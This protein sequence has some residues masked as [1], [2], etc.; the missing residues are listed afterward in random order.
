MKTCVL[1]LT[2][3][4][5]IIIHV[6]E[7]KFSIFEM[8]LINYVSFMSQN[9]VAFS[10]LFHFNF[11]LALTEWSIYL[12]TQLSQV[13]PKSFDIIS[14]ELKIALKLSIILFL[15]FADKKKWSSTTTFTKQISFL[16]CITMPEF[17]VQQAIKKKNKKKKERFEKLSDITMK[18]W[19]KRIED[20]STNANYCTYRQRKLTQ[21]K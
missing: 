2:V 13:K 1:T 21:W 15:L 17:R 6:L 20:L 16:L 5:I 19:S 18:T 10:K 3:F 8:F 9:L 14:Y 4:Q 7:Y 11:I 12:I